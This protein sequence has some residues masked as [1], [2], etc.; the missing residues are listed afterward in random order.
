[1]TNQQNTVPERKVQ[2]KVPVRTP[3]SR[4]RN[5][6]RLHPAAEALERS[7]KT[8]TTSGERVQAAKS[9]PTGT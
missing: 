5:P 4:R 3:L 7:I 9:A 1:M 2:Q 8:R 6:V